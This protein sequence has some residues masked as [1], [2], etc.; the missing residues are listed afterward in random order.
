MRPI[1]S[2][3]LPAALESTVILHRL[4]YA[5]QPAA[6]DAARAGRARGRRDAGYGQF[7]VQADFE[8]VLPHVVSLH[9]KDSV[10]RAA[11]SEAPFVFGLVPAA[12]VDCLWPIGKRSRT[13]ATTRGPCA[14]ST[15]AAAIIGK[16]R[17]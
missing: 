15:K 16:A 1:A 11:A 5:A 2:Q 4:P 17:A 12:A 3:S 10:W 7:Q 13:D 8:A 6:G 14:V 9:V